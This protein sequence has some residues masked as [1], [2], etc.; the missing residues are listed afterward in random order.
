MDIK[1]SDFDPRFLKTAQ[2]VIKDGEVSQ[3]DLSE[4]IEAAGGK[5]SDAE[6]ALI[7][8]LD[9]QQVQG[10]LK[11]AAEGKG[12]VF[13]KYA[14][15]QVVE[16]H[17]DENKQLL[18]V[19][20][21]QVNIDEAVKA[22]D[23]EKKFRLR[24]GRDADTV[25]EGL[26]EGRGLQMGIRQIRQGTSQDAAAVNQLVELAEGDR[27]VKV[28]VA[29]VDQFKVGE[30]LNLTYSLLMAKAG[31]AARDPKSPS[32][33]QIQDFNALLK[34]IQK[35]KA[36]S[37]EQIQLL[38]EFGLDCKNGQLIN[39]V[40]KEPLS[41]SQLEGLAQTAH[42]ANRAFHG[43]GI[44]DENKIARQVFGQFDFETQA[45]ADLEKARDEYLAA[46]IEVTK[47]RDQVE[48]STQSVEEQTAEVE[49]Q[50]KAVREQMGLYQELDDILASGKISPESLTTRIR[51]LSPQQLAQINQLLEKHGM[52]I[53]L[54]GGTAKFFK[55]GQVLNNEQF[56]AEM[57]PLQGRIRHDLDQQKQQLTHARAE[58]QS[59]I[60]QLDQDKQKLTES[61]ARF[62]QAGAV[63]DEAKTEADQAREQ[64]QARLNDPGE[65]AKM[66]PEELAA[67]EALLGRFNTAQI[68]YDADLAR[69]QP[70][71]DS[72]E[73]T[74]S[75]ADRALNN[76]IAALKSLDRL[77]ADFDGVFNHLNNTFDQLLADQ[78][79]IAELSEAL[80]KRANELEAQ[81][82]LMPKP[83]YVGLETL[84]EE[85]RALMEETRNN[86]AQ[87]G[88]QQH[89]HDGFETR[90]SREFL[91]KTQE[92]L[93]HH[94]D[95]LGSMDQ[96]GKE[97]MAQYIG[98]SLK[99]YQ[100]ML[101]GS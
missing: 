15:E 63:Y 93:K 17:L 6:K 92:Q 3:K 88:R 22:A 36:P 13:K 65:R 45:V 4:L 14:F 76:A 68:N 72:V 84:A 52:R 27:S 26:S 98:D 54:E 80:C 2:R 73:Q 7:A 62:E 99:S 39:P 40:S 41:A 18:E 49:R 86:F 31:Q 44:F 85:L 87:L 37:F 81:L 1:S 51:Q 29:S 50:E 69:R 48:H 11:Q 16:F 57:G 60:Q 61:T 95:Q 83:M 35:G 59:R 25:R 42:A 74:L 53:A 82:I 21:R 100:T 64:L 47:D 10:A 58:L 34:Q 8:N 24:I 78:K 9:D 5:L 97:L 30:G 91:Q 77:L 67:G 94:L 90:L 12:G 89:S 96:H 75:K 71:L 23:P 56:F 70:L 43:L 46:E 33:Q 20:H 28:Q 19:D 101:Q 79:Q 32:K 38:R 55:N 66:S